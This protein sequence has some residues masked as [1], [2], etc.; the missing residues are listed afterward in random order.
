MTKMKGRIKIF[1]SEWD[2]K[3]EKANLYCVSIN[4]KMESV[5]SLGQAKVTGIRALGS[6]IG[7]I[8]DQGVL[9]RRLASSNGRFDAAE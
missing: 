4:G 8:T 1:V 2:A 6:Y 3:A 9:L 7:L 5:I